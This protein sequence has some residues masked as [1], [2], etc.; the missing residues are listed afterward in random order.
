MLEK[1]IHD[2]IY[3]HLEQ[4][5]ILT[6]TQWGFRQNRPTTLATAKLVESISNKLNYKEHV[7]IICID[8]QKAFDL[9]NYE[10]MIHKLMMYGV[11]NAQIGW[12]RCYLSNRKQRVLV[13]GQM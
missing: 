7:G 9:I 6:D 12:F 3:D 2:R 11:N 4:N 8:L 1:I 5:N 10:L 13:N